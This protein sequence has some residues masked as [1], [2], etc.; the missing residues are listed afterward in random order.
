[1]SL[2]GVPDDL[3]RL[4]AFAARLDARL[5]DADLSRSEITELLEHLH[6]ALEEVHALYETVSE[7]SET[8]AAAMA[9]SHAERERYKYLFDHAPD[10]YVVSDFHGVIREAN[11]QASRL[12]NTALEFL[13]GLPFASFVHADHR[14]VFR[15]ELARMGVVERLDEWRVVLQPHAMP[16]IQ[17]SLT[18]SAVP[19]P[20]GRSTAL[21][22]L[23]RDVTER[24]GVATLWRMTRGRQH[25]TCT[26]A[27]T[28]GGLELSVETS[29]GGIAT[30][31]LFPDWDEVLPRSQ[32]LRTGMK[33]EGWTVVGS[34]PPRR[35]EPA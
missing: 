8:L 34:E 9:A 6:G 5:A 15:R 20:T 10:A 18:V 12:L 4:R 29:G 27:K 26:V 24:T 11:A 23:I 33:S 14:P 30:R 21:R 28:E 16:P 19:D 25:A 7:Q 13:V 22:W 2:S 1:M 17:A 31:E 3:A 35:G 32:A